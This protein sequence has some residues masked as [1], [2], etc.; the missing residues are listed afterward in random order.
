M[1]DFG[2]VAGDPACELQVAWNLFDGD[3]RRTFRDHLR[4]DDAMWARGRG[5]ALSVALVYIPYYEPKFQDRTAGVRRL[6]NRILDDHDSEH[7]W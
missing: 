3:A 4:A 2:L 1:I 5:W 7:S 6:V